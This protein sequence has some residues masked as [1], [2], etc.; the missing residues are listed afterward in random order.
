MNVS[1][2]NLWRFNVSPATAYRAAQ[3]PPP[4]CHSHRPSLAGRRCIKALPHMRALLH[5]IFGTFITQSS[6][7][8][9]FRGELGE[10]GQLRNGK[11]WQPTWLGKSEVACRRVLPRLDFGGLTFAP[12]VCAEVSARLL[13]A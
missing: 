12:A 6:F 9:G 3:K 7:H 13:V 1:G 2:D 4:H 5:K 11:R 10:L 8:P